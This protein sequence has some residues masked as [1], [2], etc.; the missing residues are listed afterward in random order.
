MQ[1]ILRGFCRIVNH[2]RHKR[3][4]KFH[5]IV[6]LQPRGLHADD[7]I[8]CRMGFVKRIL[9]KIHHGIVNTVCRFL[10]NAVC[11][12]APDA[13]RLISV[14]ETL[15]LRVND[16]LLFFTHGAADVVRLS[17][18]ITRKLLYNLHHLLL[19]DDT[20]IGWLKDRLQFRRHVS[21]G[22]CIIFSLDVVW[23]KIHRSRTVQGNS[24]NDILE[25]LR[26]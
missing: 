22:V 8:G 1:Q 20:S 17:H 13:A 18:R 14:D 4:H 10:I 16:I 3:C 7:R 25:I 2:G 21:N 11:H 23:N 6:K 5:R 26:L 12:A 19:I 24:G 9:C 15:P